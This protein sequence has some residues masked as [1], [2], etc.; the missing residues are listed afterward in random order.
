MNS[1][2]S[3]RS[4]AKEMDARDPL[5]SY[6]ERFYIPKGNNGQDCIYFCGN[7]LGLQPKSVKTYVEQEL[8]DWEKLGVEGHFHAKNPWLPYHEFLTKQTAR[9][10][11]AKSVEV[12]VMNT[13]TVNLHLMMVSFYRPTPDRHK[14]VIESHAFPSDR[15][16][17]Q[18]QIAFHGFNPETSLIEL[19]PRPGEAIIRTE[20]IEAFIEKEGELSLI[21]I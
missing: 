8:E 5:A 17:V 6:R 11:G 20:D 3:D 10:V 19:T 13:L 16:A 18:S 4:F 12:V 7:S 9:L 2:R 21:H 15:Y 14:I 1:Y